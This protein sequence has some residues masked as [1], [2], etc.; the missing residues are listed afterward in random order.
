MSD[1]STMEPDWSAVA[2]AYGLGRIRSYSHIA[3]GDEASV[4]RA[5]TECGPV[6]LKV[7]R[8]NQDTTDFERRATL[9]ERLR[10]AGIPFPRLFETVNGDVVAAVGTDLVAVLAWSHGTIQPSFN[11]ASAGSAARLLASLHSALRKQPDHLSGRVDPSRWLVEP[12]DVAARTCYML[13]DEIQQLKRLQPVDLKYQKALRERL[14]DLLGVDDIR[15]TLPALASQLVH[16]DYTRPNLL[17]DGSRV[18]AVLDLKGLFGLPIREFGKIAFEPHTVVRS[19]NWLEVACAAAMEY[20]AVDAAAGSVLW[21]CARAVILYNL[22]SFYG[23]W[24]RYVEGSREGQDD[25]DSYWLN[26]HATGRLLL[27]NLRFV[28]DQLVDACAR[29]IAHLGT[30][31]DLRKPGRRD[32]VSLH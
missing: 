4:W 1:V 7:L 10:N 8:S 18:V 17:F 25:M 29:P 26:R 30:S 21:S 5:E 9:M 13:L 28:E 15:R 32:F 22:F 14:D 2:C 24:E 31:M 16:H 27:A 6:C 3:A 12:A 20:C 11:W 19:A 23:P